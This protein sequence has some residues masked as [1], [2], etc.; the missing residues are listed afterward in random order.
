M[1]GDGGIILTAE[2]LIAGATDP[3]AREGMGVLVAEGRIT[4]IAPLEDLAAMAPGAERLHLE[5]CVLMPGLVNA[6]QH[7]RGLT[8]LQLGF[9]DM[10]LEA[11]QTTKRRR[12]WL[13]PAAMVPLA[14][15]QMLASGITATIHANTTWGAAGRQPDDLA[16]TIAAYDAAGLRA[17]V[18]IG[19]QDRASLVF[20]AE[21]QTGFVA[22]LPPELVE[23]VGNPDPP[24]FATTAEEAAALYD[25]LS[26]QLPSHGRITLAFAPAGP[27]WVSDAL[28]AGIA[29]AAHA[30]GGVPIHMHALESV[31]QAAAARHLYPE[32]TLARLEALGVLGPA[33]S[34]A[35]AAQLTPGDIS[36]A[37]RSGTMLV[38]NP[39][40]NL[41]LGCGI[42]PL[43]AYWAAGVGVAIGTDCQA[44]DDEEDLWK[45]LR[46]AARLATEASWQAA[47]PPDAATLLAMATTQ[48]AAAMGLAG[49]VGQLAPGCAADCIAVD[50]RRVRGVY[51]DPS[52]PLLDLLLARAD[53]RDVRLTM[54]QGRVLYRDGHFPHLDPQAIAAAAA[55][56]A[57][58]ARAPWSA[59]REAA[60]AALVQAVRAHYAT[61]AP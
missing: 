10:I 30:R 44:M 26:D 39:A 28:F 2:A 23:L 51:A 57:A 40:S 3:A 59:G 36:V 32:G 37:A 17:L 8:Q 35:H 46:L 60:V 55:E 58:R 6:H 18:G 48:G 5:H 15:M 54:V 11:W 27:Q 33:T 34:L 50:L 29:K 53:A 4:A 22:G 13:D 52:V 45:E 12:G 20:P 19:A 42:A 1:S 14:G 7:G 49:R 24:I 16:R 31:A 21:D 25:S 9:P 56:A 38:R 43:A 47:G 61:R 41:R